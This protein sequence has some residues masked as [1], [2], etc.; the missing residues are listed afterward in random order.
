MK[1]MM[2]YPIISY[3]V[4]FIFLPAIQLVSLPPVVNCFQSIFVRPSPCSKNYGVHNVNRF[5]GKNSVI[6]PTISD[7]ILQ[8]RKA[9]S[10][11]FVASTSPPSTTTP[12]VTVEEDMGKFKSTIVKC[13]MMTYI[14]SMCVAL[15]VTLFPIF[16]LRKLKVLS[17]TQSEH[18]SL[19]T[20]QFCA[21]WLLRLIPFIKLDVVPY[22][23]QNPEPSVWVC[24][25]VSMLDIFIILAA[26]KKMRG[27]NRRPMKSIYVSDQVILKFLKNH[28]IYI[29]QLFT[30]FLTFQLTFLCLICV[31]YVELMCLIMDILY[32]GVELSRI[33]FVKFFFVCV[34]LSQ[35]IW[36]T[37]GMVTQM[38]MTNQNLKLC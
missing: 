13:M 24:N 26:D 16:L 20:G 34:V 25:H 32:S 37:M 10:K 1:K 14:S 27:K 4:A 23:E 11:S 2:K 29:S 19:I 12:N 17:K 6:F 28:K 21:R 3:T 38:P 7:S 30:S 5:Q 9:F 8:K 31:Y 15:P 35:L 36:K 33:Q 22:K 18:Q